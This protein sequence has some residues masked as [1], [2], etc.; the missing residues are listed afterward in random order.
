M[1]LVTNWVINFGKK[2]GRSIVHVNKSA[3]ALA[4]VLA[5]TIARV[6]RKALTKPL[7]A[8]VKNPAKH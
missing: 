1:G 4:R 3:M 7:T 2:V 8:D 6:K 5:R